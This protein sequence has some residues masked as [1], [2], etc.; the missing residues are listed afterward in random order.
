[1]DYGPEIPS[2]SFPNYIFP[3]S[4]EDD[5][6]V[7]HG[8][9][10]NGQGGGYE[11][12][13]N[14]HPQPATQ[15]SEHAHRNQDIMQKSDDSRQAHRP[16]REGP[17]HFAKNDGDVNNDAEQNQ[18]DSNDALSLELTSNRRTDRIK[19]LFFKYRAGRSAPDLGQH[20]LVLIFR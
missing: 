9:P 6:C 20:F 5:D 2:Q 19:S 4:V 16:R 15:D 12:G 8:I 3:D 18:A 14:L 11:N 1:M 17:G 13:T 7:R 10:K